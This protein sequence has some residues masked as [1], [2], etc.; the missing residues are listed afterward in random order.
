[1]CALVLNTFCHVIFLL[2]LIIFLLNFVLVSNG[3][4]VLL[5]PGEGEWA[6]TRKYREANIN[7]KTTTWFQKVVPNIVVWPCS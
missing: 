4:I 6:H 1:M 5:T 7:G 3:D 2:L